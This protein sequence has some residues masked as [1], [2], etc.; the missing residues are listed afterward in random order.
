MTG[1][2]GDHR[3]TPF[4]LPERPKATQVRQI[5]KSALRGPAGPRTMPMQGFEDQFV[6][7]VDYIVRIT[8]EI[9]T[10]RAIGRIYD[11]YDASCTIYSPYG[12]TRSVEE[13]VAN[14]IETMTAFPEDEALHLNVAWSGDGRQGFYTSHLG[15][16]RT[17]NSGASIWGPATGREVSYCFVADCISRDN[18]IHTEWLVHDAGAL[19]RALGLSID[20]AAERVAAL[21]R[22]ESFLLVPASPNARPRPAEHRRTTPEGWM[23]GFLDDIWTARRLD[24]IATFYAADAVTHWAGGRTAVGPGDLA[25]LIVA[26]MTALPDAVMDVEHICW[27]E[28]RDGI[29]VA[30]R[31]KLSGSTRRGGILGDALPE[32]RFIAVPGISH[33]RFKDGMIAEEWTVFDEV[34]A[35]AGALATR[36]AA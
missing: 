31:W 1:A 22:A 5:D 28:E 16:L 20:E 9:W 11:T 12:V 21:P 34:A 35:V 33:F 3:D 6:D 4:A 7:I 17:T 29:V 32:G 13:V 27:S 23:R 14:T 24:R 25:G 18:R 30:V 15:W 8:E 36:H 19:V 26:T 2:P 10:D